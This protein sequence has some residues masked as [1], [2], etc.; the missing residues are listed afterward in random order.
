MS[1]EMKSSGTRME[2]DFVQLQLEKKSV[3]CSES[4]RITI[5]G[6]T[7]CEELFAISS[8]LNPLGRK[9]RLLFDL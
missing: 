7:S 9:L 4:D 6:A 8:Y 3:H 1:S 5:Y 2:F